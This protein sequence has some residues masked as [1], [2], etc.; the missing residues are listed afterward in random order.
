LDYYTILA[1]SA[2]IAKNCAGAP[3][4]TVRRSGRY[5]LFLGFG[6][7]QALKLA[8]TP[9]MPYLHAVDPRF[10]PRRDAQTWH[11]NLFEKRILMGVTV[12]H[13][14][15]VITFA[16]EGGYSL[17]F[18]MTGRHANIIIT[19]P[20]G[21][22]KGALRQVSTTESTVRAVMPGLPYEPPP[23]RSYPDLLDGDPSE[24][25]R[26]LAGVDGTIEQALRD[27]L[28]C[29]SRYAASEVCRRAGVDPLAVA[30]DIDT[31]VLSRIVDE[32]VS[33]NRMVAEGGLGGCVVFRKDG[34]PHDV[35]PYRFI[36]GEPVP[37]YYDDIDEAVR[38]YSREREVEL[39]RR[40]IRTGILAVLAAEERRILG[41]IAK[42]QQERGDDTEP[43]TLERQANTLL[44]NLRLI[45]RGDTSVELPDLYDGGTVAIDLDP[46]LDGPANARRLFK[47]A[48][49]LRAAAVLAANR[50]AGL[51]SRL[52]TIEAD[53]AEAEAVT[54][55]RE[56]R[57]LSARHVH[58]QNVRA[59]EESEELF[60]RRFTSVSGLEIVVGRNDE[61]ND[62]LVRWA[63]K[64]DYWLHAQS[65]GGSHVILR[66]PGRQEP[67]KRSIEQAAA[68]AAYY[69]K[70]KTSGLVPVVCTPVKYVVKRK[71]QGPGK[72]TYTREKVLF[73]EP[74]QPG[75]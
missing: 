54:D 70:G 9:D 55:I 65:I 63:R 40:S 45:K 50:L 62:A 24:L 59:D 44:A 37:V 36:D 38:V 7:D 66:S 33:L 32:A 49:K 73:V 39:E 2:R 68:I 31:N 48:K 4:E 34:L 17:I 25:A 72:V 15:R 30:A 60:P 47:R 13:G 28:V 16:F 22:I 21:A 19:G 14:D 29:G 74:H 43:E 58:V 27:T 26:L 5:T 8:G 56:L 69:S 75:K 11:Q 20:D 53:R 51:Q 57:K 64:T 35:L 3:V 61:E 18:E 67:D 23:H 71:G 52:S 46:A 12:T 6:N 41:T 1:Q 42:V 10:I